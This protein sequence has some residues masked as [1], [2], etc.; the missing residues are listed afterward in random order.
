MNSAKK[1]AD[2][3]SLEMAIPSVTVIRSR[4]GGNVEEVVLPGNAQAY[5]ATPIYARTKAVSGRQFNRLIQV[6]TA[7]RFCNAAAGPKAENAE[8]DKVAT[9][10]YRWGRCNA[11]SLKVTDRSDEPWARA[12]NFWTSK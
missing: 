9:E 3:S 8:R 5:V 1:P 6:H 4:P 10:A 2:F 7:A 11:K 12:R